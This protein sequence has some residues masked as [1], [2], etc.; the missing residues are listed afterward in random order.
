MMFARKTS[1]KIKPDFAQDDL[2]SQFPQCIK[3]S[4]VFLALRN[5]VSYIE[6]EKED[7]VM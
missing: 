6:K 5:Y 2:D 7:I 3:S 4:T 1:S